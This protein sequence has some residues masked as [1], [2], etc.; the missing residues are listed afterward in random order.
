M[1]E[2]FSKSSSMESPSLFES[3]WLPG[4]VQ[5]LCVTVTSVRGYRSAGSR[6]NFLGLGSVVCSDVI[7]LFRSP[8]CD[9]PAAL[10]LHMDQTSEAVPE[11]LDKTGCKTGKQAFI[12]PSVGSRAVV[13]SA[14]TVWYVT[15]GLSKSFVRASIRTIDM[16]QILQLRDAVSVDKS[17]M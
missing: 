11:N 4:P 5:S 9:V 1:P 3:V 16:A 12:T 2:W 17:I 8:S 6:W 13:M 14:R 10:D 7:P 15:S